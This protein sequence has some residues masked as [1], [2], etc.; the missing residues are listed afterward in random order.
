MHQRLG[1]LCPGAHDETDIRGQRRHD[2]PQDRVERI[3]REQVDV[4]HHHTSRPGQRLQRRAQQGHGDVFVEWW[5]QWQAEIRPGG[6]ECGAQT[7]R[8]PRRGRGRARR[9]GTMR[10][11]PP[12]PQRPA[13]PARSCPTRPVPPA[14]RPGSGSASCS[15]RG[16]STPPGSGGGLILYRSIWRVASRVLS[17]I[18]VSRGTVMATTGG[19]RPIAEGSAD[20]TVNR[21]PTI[22]RTSSHGRYTARTE[23]G[24][25][26][27]QEP[28]LADV[29]PVQERQRHLGDQRGRH[30]GSARLPSRGPRH[31]RRFR[32]LRQGR[33]D[34]GRQRATRRGDVLLRR[35]V[36][37]GR[38]TTRTRPSRTEL[39]PNGFTPWHWVHFRLGPGPD[40]NANVAHVGIYADIVPQGHYWKPFTAPLD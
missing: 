15:R 38:P 39:A 19:R 24:R 3:G 23:H 9:R 10:S 16:R 36:R 28:D 29:G 33:R 20:R 7:G 26:R 5:R 25:L 30:Q 11:V 4:V 34:P 22:R 2:D 6:V 13:P 12:S 21:T 31:E 18:E 8:R 1:H 27:A 14:R 35:H 32:D 17:G 40:E 37:P